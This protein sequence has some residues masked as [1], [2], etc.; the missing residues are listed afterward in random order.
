MNRLSTL[1]GALLISIGLL[2]YTQVQRE[3]QFDLTWR[4]LRGVWLQIDNGVYI[5]AGECQR[6]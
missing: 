6:K 5:S 3:K 2:I 1:F 4:E